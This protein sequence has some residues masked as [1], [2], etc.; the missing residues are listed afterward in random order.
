M[1]PEEKKKFLIILI[2]AIVVVLLDQ[3]LKILIVKFGNNI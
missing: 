3:I 2:T 1:K